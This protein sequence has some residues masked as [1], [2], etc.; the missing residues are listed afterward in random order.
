MPYDDD[1]VAHGDESVFFAFGSFVD[2]SHGLIARFVMRFVAVGVTFGTVV[3]K[4]T[5]KF[6]HDVRLCV[7]RV[8]EEGLVAATNHVFSSVSS[9][10]NVKVGL[11][12]QVGQPFQGSERMGFA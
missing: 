10:L 7:V 4:A 11:T 8:H 5:M 12:V 2:G 9:V 1:A 3:P 6:V